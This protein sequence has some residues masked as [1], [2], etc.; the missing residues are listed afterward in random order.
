MATLQLPDLPEVRAARD[1]IR[2]HVH[3]TPLLSSRSLGEAHGARLHLKA[4]NLQRGGAFKIRGALNAVL[5]ARERGDIGPEGVITYSS[6]NH[7][8]A[9][10]LAAQ[11]VGV[12]GTVFVPEDIAAV[13]RAAIEEYGARVVPCGLTSVDRQKG[14][15]ELAG[16]T[17]AF[18]VPPYDHPD[19][20]AG[21]GTTALEIVE[22]LPD[23]EAILVPVG[24]G[25][26]I[27]G[28]A[29]AAKALKPGVRIIGVEPETA[30]DMALSLA[31]GRKVSIPPSRTIAD[32]LRAL[33]PGDL[34]F[35]AAR[36]C[37][38]EIWCVDDESIVTAQERLLERTKLFVEPSG[39]AAVAAFL[40]HGERLRTRT[41]AVVL[42][43]GNADVPHLG[44][45]T[46]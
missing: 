13:K 34:T 15:E 18:I 35:E 42:S 21:Q 3:R 5:K 22:D 2:E 11:I 38:D 44:G 32:G 14:A 28:I 16:R 8:Q 17:G 7:G 6:G 12:P 41:V 37:V 1:R 30:N 23:V 46:R 4:E 20:I 26:L 33:T 19:I 10:A 27:S 43:G 39:A 45:Q 36:R 9:V 24:G 29:I 31:A 25:G 40:V